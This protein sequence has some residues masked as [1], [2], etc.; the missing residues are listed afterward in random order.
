MPTRAKVRAIVVQFFSIQTW[1][2]SDFE[3]SVG[4]RSCAQ[5]SGAAT[6]RPA[7]E[8]ANAPAGRGSTRQLC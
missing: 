3:F 2:K 8:R 7:C 5:V 1:L 6:G 4:L